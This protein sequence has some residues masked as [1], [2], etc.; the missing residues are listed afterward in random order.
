MVSMKDE[1]SWKITKYVEETAEANT[2]IQLNHQE[3]KKNYFDM[4]LSVEKN[5]E[6]YD[7]ILNLID[8][9]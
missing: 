5:K 4:C 9:Q 6:K 8:K 3:I 1:V 2:E 7:E